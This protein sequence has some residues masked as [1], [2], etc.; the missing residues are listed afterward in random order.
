MSY[1]IV[2][3]GCCDYTPEMKGWS[4]LVSVPLTLEVDDFKTLD[5][6]N[7][8][9]ADFVRRMRAFDGPAKSACPS[10]ESW[11][12]AYEGP[13]DEL[14]VLTITGKL[15]GTYNS[16]VQAKKVYEEEYGTAKKI[17]VFDSKATSGK[18][19][20]IAMKIKELA[21][22]G[23]AFEQVIAEIDPFINRCE[24]HFCL[25]NLEN[26]HKNGRLSNLQSSLL[27]VLR[28]KL[29]MKEIDGD[30]HKITQDISI[31]RSMMKMADLIAKSL[32]KVDTS[33]QYLVVTHCMNEERGK[34]VYDRILS[35]CKF[36]K[37]WL[38]GMGGLNTLYAN[39]GGVLVGLSK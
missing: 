24:L 29:I 3:D 33:D 22:T 2:T 13:E 14:Y 19:T 1:K 27:G 8:D 16:A 4:N 32:E 21:E 26:L 20:I 28:V 17:H 9:Q 12:K 25:D 23:M 35:K 7:F 15:S 38:L 36:K 31:N 5:D 18:E 39:E 37:A 30:I 34:M 6:A 10:I 11:M